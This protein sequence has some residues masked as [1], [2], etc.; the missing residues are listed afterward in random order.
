QRLNLPFT[1]L[2][3]FL[4]APVCSRLDEL[5]ADIAI[6][7]APTDEGSTW[8]PGARFGP[9]VIREMSFRRAGYGGRPHGYYD[10]GEERRYLERE[11]KLGRIVDCG[12]SD[13]IYT[14]VQQT[15]DNITQDVS[16]IRARGAM[17]VVIGGDHAITYP[18]VR[19][20]TGPLDVIH[21]DAHL[22]YSPF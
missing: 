21:F 5:D 3:S 16:S 7:G 18:V 9:R 15:F 22:D 1:G 11:L 19:G 4:R 6:L 20:F 2:V 12:D 10:M 8:V 14:N 13:I 17:P